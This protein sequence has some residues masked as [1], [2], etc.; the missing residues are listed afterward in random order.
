MTVPTRDKGGMHLEGLSAVAAV[1]TVAFVLLGALVAL[2]PQPPGLE[3]AVDRALF[4]SKDT[5]AFRLFHVITI[6]GSFAFVA[7]GAAVL[8][9][10][11]WRHSR[12]LRL[13]AGCIL[14]PGLAGVA[15]I[16]LKPLVGRARPS[17]S[18]LTGERGFGFPSGHATGATALAVCAITV[19]WALLAPGPRRAATIAIS[20]GYAAVIGLSRVV[21]GAH[22]LG[23]VLGGC[24]LGTAVATTV[25]AVLR[26]PT[27]IRRLGDDPTAP[28]PG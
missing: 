18:L 28:R 9:V 2:H 8:G 21:V 27:L 13:A 25:F 16:G 12:D 11:C 3:T 6:A 5:I 19:A 22:H 24:A 20:A 17:T 15:E 23:D 26:P 4:A 7:A 10:E 1:C 14:G